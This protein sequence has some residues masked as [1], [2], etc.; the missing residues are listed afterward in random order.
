[1][2]ENVERKGV[3]IGVGRSYR[4]GTD[5]RRGREG[6]RERERKVRII[7]R[8][9]QSGKLGAGTEE[10][11]EGERGYNEMDCGKPHLSLS[12]FAAR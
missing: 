5:G 3:R 8:G 10:L 9:E 2:N 6:E 4:T 1:M 7:K 11:S 12:A